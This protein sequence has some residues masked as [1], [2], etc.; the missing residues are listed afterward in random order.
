[1]SFRTSSS[2]ALLLALATVAHPA[3][4]PPLSPLAD[5]GNG[6]LRRARLLGWLEGDSLALPAWPLA[7]PA[8]RAPG[9]EPLV[10]W[11]LSMQD[12]LGLGSDAVF[13]LGTPDLTLAASPVLLASTATAGGLACDAM[14]NGLDLEARFLDHTAVQFAFRDAQ[15]SGDLAVVSHPGLPRSRSWLW[16]ETS[17]DARSLTHDETR[18]RLTWAAP[19]GQQSRL[20]LGL[21][22]DQPV[23]GT[24]LLGGVILRGEQAPAMN[25]MHASL[26]SGRLNLLFMAAELESRLIDSLHVHSDPVRVRVPWRQK[27]LVGHR[28]DWTGTFGSLGVGELV[29]VGDE[30]PGPGYLNPVNFLWSE[31]HASGDKDNT[32]LFADARLRFPRQLPGR[33]QVH[34]ELALD[35]YTLGDLGSRAEGQKSATLLGLAWSPPDGWLGATGPEPVRRLWLIAEQRR[36]RPFF[37]THFHGINSYSHGGQSLMGSPQP[38]SRHLDLALLLDQ[39]LPAA[40][41]GFLRLPPSLLS[42]AIEGGQRLHG[43]NPDGVNVGGDLEQG[44]RE[45]LDPDVVQLLGGTLERQDFRRLEL[46]W[47]QP[48]ALG[49]ASSARPAGTLHLGVALARWHG[50]GMD[51]A[52]EWVR[53]FTLAWGLSSGPG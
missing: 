3:G 28:L 2:L 40:G 27:W 20:E 29:V 39:R 9:S 13:R 15:E 26:A 44:H 16:Q 47:H 10:A 32:L 14:G 8:G 18:V 48:L 49:R 30:V 25:R 7:R 24:G 53:E 37:G 21:A 31:Q 41:L 12:S 38:N 51:P 6:G 45:G 36:I 33:G 22:R 35:D 52:G 1:M 46:Q 11:H 42:L 4:Q 23:W 43:A 50:H 5:M 34:G 19:V 17:P